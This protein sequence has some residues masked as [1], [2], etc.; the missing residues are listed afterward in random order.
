MSTALAERLAQL[1]KEAAEAG[2]SGLATTGPDR[3]I[4][5]S[6]KH[7]NSM[8]DIPPLTLTL[9]RWSHGGGSGRSSKR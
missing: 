9:Q 5:R 7:L 6:T 1:E 2:E 3:S 8:N 4:D